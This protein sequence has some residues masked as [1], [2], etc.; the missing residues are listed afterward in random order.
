MLCFCCT[1]FMMISAFSFHFISYYVSKYFH[2]WSM[3]LGTYLWVYEII[4]SF[5]IP[6]NLDLQQNIFKDY[7][8]WRSWNFQLAHNH[9]ISWKDRKA[10]LTVTYWYQNSLIE[11]KKPRKK[12]A[13]V[14]YRQ[15][16]WFL[17]LRPLREDIL[18]L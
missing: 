18:I 12:F 17:Y 6:S 4:I 1:V 14:G 9:I 15:T 11:I 13:K 2:S 8:Y 7:C 10:L 5:R 16:C 3:L